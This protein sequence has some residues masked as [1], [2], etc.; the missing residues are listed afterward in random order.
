MY[1]YRS[2]LLEPALMHSNISLLVPDPAD[3]RVTSLVAQL[4]EAVGRALQGLGL[5]VRAP[6]RQGCGR[7]HEGAALRNLM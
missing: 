5:E 1:P 7:R 3:P 6:D 2:L 4:N